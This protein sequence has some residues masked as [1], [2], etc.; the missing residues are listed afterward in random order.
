MWHGV[1]TL[2]AAVLATI[3]L[4][5]ILAENPDDSVLSWIGFIAAGI[6]VLITSI[7]LIMKKEAPVAALSTTM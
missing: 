1:L 3:S 6:W 5:G 7:L 2:V 4:L